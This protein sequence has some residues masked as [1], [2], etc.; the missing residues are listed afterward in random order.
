MK[1]HHLMVLGHIHLEL[2]ES[3]VCEK[4]TATA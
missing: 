2:E 3:D 1:L 4:D